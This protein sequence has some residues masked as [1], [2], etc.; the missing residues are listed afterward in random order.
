MKR[1]TW[2]AC[3]AVPLALVAIPAA[4]YGIQDAISA[5]TSVQGRVV[6]VF[7]NRFV[8]QNDAGKI[9]VDG[10][11]SWYQDLDFDVGEQVAV[12]GR[13]EHEKFEALTIR[14]GDGSLVTVR[15]TFE[16]PPWAGKRRG[17][18]GRIYQTA[19]GLFETDSALEGTVGDVFGNSFVVEGSAGAVL[20]DAGPA[21][22]QQI[23]VRS[24]ERVNITGR[25]AD[26]NLDAIVIVREDG[27]M[28]Q[29]RPASGRP[30]W[31]GKNRQLLSALY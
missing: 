23:D 31:A 6:A 27:T 16:Q 26:D 3:A 5:Q 19:A 8:L 28:E 30:P 14:R 4:V 1:L 15:S 13:L 18:L 25:L 21:W 17:M 9:L 2:A 12:A 11:P 20:V 7:G 24:G 29:I 22:Y 10:G